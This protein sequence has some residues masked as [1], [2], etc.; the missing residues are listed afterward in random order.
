MH[1]IRV[2]L[3]VVMSVIWSL[4]S[5][6]EVCDDMEAGFKR[7]E[8][9][10][11]QEKFNEYFNYVSVYYSEVAGEKEMYDPAL[12][13]RF[14][15]MVVRH[16]RRN[17][18]ALA[19]VMYD[20]GLNANEVEP[21]YDLLERELKY[22][23]P[24]LTSNEQDEL[25]GLLEDSDPAIYEKIRGIWNTR[26][27]IIS[28]G[29]NERLIEHWERILFSKK[30]F[31]K[32]DTTVYG[33]D[34]RGKIYVRLGEPTNI[35]RGR[36]GQSSSEVRAKIYDLQGK[37]YIHPQA[38]DEVFQLQQ[39]VM[40]SMIPVEVE[41]WQ[42]YDVTEIE[43]D[44]I[45]F[46]FGRAGGSG[47]YGLR[48]SVEEFIPS[49]VFNISA[50]GRRGTNVDIRI[51][52]FL[53]FVLY[54]E[55][56]TYD[57]FF[58][59]RLQEYDRTWHQTVGYDRMNGL[60]LRNRMSRS[61]ALRATEQVY[62]Q[63]PIDTSVY[64]RRLQDFELE[65]RQYR[66][67]DD[68]KQ[69][70][71]ISIIQSSPQDLFDKFGDIA[72]QEGEQHYKLHL[73][74]GVVHY[75][76]KNERLEP[77]IRN[78]SKIYDSKSGS[79]YSPNSAHS[80]SI[81][82]DIRYSVLFSELYFG[83]PGQS[84]Q[85]ENWSLVGMNKERKNNP[86][87][88]EAGTDD[89]LMSDIILGGTAGDTVQIRNETIGLIKDQQIREGENLQVYFEVYNL[90]ESINDYVSYETEYRIESGGHS[91]WPFSRSEEQS[92]TWESVSEGWNDTQFFEVEHSGLD[93]GNY[94]LHIKID[95]TETDRVAERSIDF[96]I[97]EQK[98]EPRT[99]NR[100]E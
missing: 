8:C 61:R 70:E 38:S 39:H 95:E 37:G 7:A 32:N 98:D 41:L 55:L 60:N 43:R 35:E 65:Y 52:T 13:F 3:A 59:N 86:A 51:G 64:E 85:P 67:L 97:I 87:I 80:T 31:T 96:K 46:L 90:D 54:N 48:K 28:S 75:D 29:V 82:A 18:A 73:K 72:G 63:A 23:Q 20:W 11:E 93:P 68:Q 17:L 84:D 58:G 49:T 76:S 24:L 91:W 33:T 36:I 10:I 27:V 30:H 14:M 44:N 78:I 74:Q 42:Y 100:N 1:P 26:D 62:N 2:S 92:L 40:S 47:P 4:P 21:F 50:F 57:R 66:F 69:P 22:M 53:Q 99:A 56:S 12:G 71:L 9:Y 77:K 34:D 19:S 6:A 25:Y 89:L 81:S 15:E 79:G 94:T 83:I 5:A 45:F 16:E 88:L